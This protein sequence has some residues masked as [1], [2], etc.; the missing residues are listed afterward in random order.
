VDNTIRN[1]KT[2]HNRKNLVIKLL[3]ALLACS[4]VAH[5]WLA[6][7]RVPVSPALGYEINQPAPWKNAQQPYLRVATYNI[8]HGKGTDGTTDLN[9]TALALHDADII[10]LNEVAGPSL[11]SSSDQAQKLGRLLKTGWLFAPNQR[12][13]YHDYFGNG[14]LSRYKVTRWYRE[15]LVY[16]SYKS[17]SHRNLLTAQLS[18][19]GR[20]IAVLVTHLDR[21]SI[22]DEQLRYVLDKFRHYPFAI[23]LGD[24]NTS[25]SDG[26]LVELLGD[27][28]NVDAIAVLLGQADQEGR[29]DWIITRGFKVVTGGI[30]PVGVSDHPCYWVELQ[31]AAVGQPR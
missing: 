1:H 28:N 11:F 10:A 14:L 22:R 19:A 2:V 3:A 21:G 6:D 9:R 7:R 27:P 5:I 20:D 26:Q 24:L 8:H 23:L 17:D 25:S 16:D 31:P 18:F 15:Q 13:W 29:I 4:L 12:R 30:Y